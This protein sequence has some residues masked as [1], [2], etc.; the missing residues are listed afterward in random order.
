MVC[1]L[2]KKKTTP[3]AYVGIC[4]RRPSYVAVREAAAHLVDGLGLEEAGGWG[5]FRVIETAEKSKGS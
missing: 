2:E 5:A 3:A 4:D 1:L